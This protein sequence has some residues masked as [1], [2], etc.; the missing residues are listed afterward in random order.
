MTHNWYDSFIDALGKKYPKKSQ[1]TEALM[2][3]LCIER[4]AAYRRLR[5]E[6]QF[7][8]AEI[9]KIASEWH[10]SLDET[11]GIMSPKVLFQLQVMNYIKPSANDMDF[12]CKRVSGLK[13]LK[14]YPDSEF[15][16]VTNNLTRTLSAGFP[17]LYRFTVL[18]WAYL[19][20]EEEQILPYS[21]TIIPEKL[22]KEVAVYYR[23]V[24]EVGNTSYIL[25]GMIFENIVNDI[26][27]FH[28]VLLV[29]DEEKELI[30]QDLY[31]LL[32]YLLEIAKQGCFPE[33][34]KKVQ[35]Y[36]SLLDINT[37]YSYFFDGT[38]ATARIHAFNM[39][40]NICHNPEMIEKFKLWMNRTKKISVQIS[41]ADEKRRIEFFI[42]QRELIDGL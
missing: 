24:K 36:A 6:V 9:A 28:S 37:N 1:L 4:E 21:Q 38:E 25:D 18:K 12:V 17:S 15:I 13:Q 39:L 8:V 23:D 33:T 32:D 31:A 19:Y 3:L 41:E 42:K 7:S 2:D 5:K 14:D 27:F 29:N 35:I 11:I 22:L 20:A 10:I 16:L 34:K 40:D 26:R 30:K